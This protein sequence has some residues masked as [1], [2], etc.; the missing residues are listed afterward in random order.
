MIVIRLILRAR[1]IR[2]ALGG[3]GSGGL[4][5]AIATMFIESC[6][7]FTVN[8]LLVL[9]LMS[10]GSGTLDIFI[11]TLPGTQVRVFP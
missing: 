4:C 1:N 3:T 7:L 8:S 6:T 5:K 10:A 2:I 11:L 9:V